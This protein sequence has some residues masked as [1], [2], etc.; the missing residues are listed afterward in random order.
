MPVQSTANQKH[1]L[2]ELEI[3]IR[4]ISIRLLCVA[5]LDQ[6]DH[7]YHSSGIATL[8]ENFFSTFYYN[9]TTDYELDLITINAII[10]VT[11]QLLVYKKRVRKLID[12]L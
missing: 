12:P 1:F 3:K 7:Y 5:P 9:F 11:R 2:K 4:M 8:F 6:D 10:L